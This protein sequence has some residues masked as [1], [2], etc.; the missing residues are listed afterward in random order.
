MNLKKFLSRYKINS[1]NPH[2]TTVDYEYVLV[3]L[4]R[5]MTYREALGTLE[6]LSLRPATRTEL[7]EYEGWD[8][9]SFIIAM[10][11]LKE[12]LG[13]KHVYIL[14]YMYS[15]AGKNCQELREHKLLNISLPFLAES[16]L[17]AIKEL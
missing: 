14:N 6:E 2:I 8:T 3:K 5:D 12:V 1:L 9:Q 13:E 15:C 17:L 11:S 16:C 7:Y 4:G 10:G